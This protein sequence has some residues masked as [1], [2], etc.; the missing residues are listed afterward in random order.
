MADLRSVVQEKLPLT[1]GETFALAK[2][3]GVRVVDVVLT[4][5]EL[6]TGLDR[7]TVKVDSYDFT[8]GTRGFN[9]ASY[10][11]EVKI[12]KNGELVL[13]FKES[14]TLALEDPKAI[15]GE[16]ILL[17][18]STTPATKVPV[19]VTTGL[20]NT[21]N[22]I[23]G[24][25]KAA[26]AEDVNGKWGKNT[27]MVMDDEGGYVKFSNELL[28]GVVKM[29]ADEKTY[30]NLVYGSHAASAATPNTE[31][32][33]DAIEALLGEAYVEE[34]ITE[35][36]TFET[37]AF[38]NE[39]AFSYAAYQDDPHYFYLYKDGKL[40]AI[41]VKYNEDEEVEAWQWNAIAEGTIIVTDVEI[42]LA[43][44]EDKNPDTGANDL[45]G[46][47]AV[48]AVVS[49]LAAGAVSLKK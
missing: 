11:D 2:E 30:L 12:N 39:V 24:D 42:V 36:Y 49:L 22:E 6:R 33:I 31:D 13:T 16:I 35:Y 18:K 25:R 5:S 15:N 7:K 3:Y 20:N 37:R 8:T 21:V 28:N 27:V 10:I 19:S 48:L 4:E 17:D 34:A 40:T 45:V 32:T 44:V 29:N 26:E 47:A 38:K 41:D 43:D 46:A 1:M 14:F 9:G 23:Y